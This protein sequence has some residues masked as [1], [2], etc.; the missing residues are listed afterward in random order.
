MNTDCASVR[1]G[2]ALLTVFQ[3]ARK[4]VQCSGLGHNGS[5]KTQK[6]AGTLHATLAW[7]D[8]KSG[9]YEQETTGFQR[10]A[11]RQ[12]TKDHTS[13]TNCD[14]AGTYTHRRSRFA[15]WPTTFDCVKLITII[16]FY[17]CPFTP[18]SY[19]QPA[20]M[21]NSNMV[22][23]HKWAGLRRQKSGTSQK[24]I[25]RFRLD[26]ANLVEHAPLG[27]PGESFQYTRRLVF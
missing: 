9:R 14:G 12:K 8:Q 11:Q 24:P 23:M 22:L 10:P 16:P 27:L 13:M 18:P 3:V 17:R 7:E 15:V 19:H 2:L 25:R 20:R 4:R 1:F 6:N 5:A 21:E 26:V